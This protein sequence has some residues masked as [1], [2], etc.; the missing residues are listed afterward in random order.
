MI[1]EPEYCAECG[2]ILPGERY[3]NLPPYITCHPCG[4]KCCDRDC[5]VEHKRFCAP[6]KEAKERRAA[7][8]KP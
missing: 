7:K 1:T 3:Y 8:G 6:S 5:L 4:A 2:S